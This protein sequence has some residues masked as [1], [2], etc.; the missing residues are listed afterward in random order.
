MLTVRLSSCSPYACALGIRHLSDVTRSWPKGCLRHITFLFGCQQLG[1]L[2][3]AAKRAS[4]RLRGPHLNECIDEA[5][6]APQQLPPD[7]VAKARKE[8]QADVYKC[9]RT[10]MPPGPSPAPSST[11]HPLAWWLVTVVQTPGAACVIG[12]G[13]C[14]AVMLFTQALVRDCCRTIVRIAQCVVHA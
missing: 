6:S 8:L 4:N 12:S 5:M 7:V 14:R 10:A 2:P 3:Q 13:G 11:S 9:G 1:L